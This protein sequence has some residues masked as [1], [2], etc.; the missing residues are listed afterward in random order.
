MGQS[1]KVIDLTVRLNGKTASYDRNVE[2]S[3]KVNERFTKSVRGVSSGLTAVEGPLNGIAGR[4]TAL[5]PIVTGSAGALAAVGAAFAGSSLLTINAMKRLS[6]YEV[7]QLKIQQILKATGYAAGLSSEEL[8]AQADAVALAT[9]ASVEDIQQAQGVLL[10]FKAVQGE[11]FNEAIR[12]SQ[13]MAAVFGGSA[14]DK[15]LQL[16][17][18][19]SSPTDGLNALKRSG[20]DFTEEQKRMIRQMDETGNRAEAQRLILKQLQDQIGGSASAQAQGLAGSVDTLGQRWDEAMRAFANST[21]ANESAKSFLNTL[22][23]GLE[24]VTNALNGPTDREKFAELV[25]ERADLQADL[26]KLSKGERTGFLSYIIG[27]DSEWYNVQRRLGE[28]NKEMEKLQNG[29]KADTIKKSE[30]EELTAVTQKKL[31]EKP[32]FFGFSDQQ[33]KAGLERMEYAISTKEERERMAAENRQNMLDA[34]LFSSQVTEARW[35]ELSTQNWDNYQTKITEIQS[36]EA[37]KRADDEKKQAEALKKSQQEN[38]ASLKNFNSQ[39]L[40][41]LEQSGK[42]RSALYKALFAAQKLAAIPAMITDTEKA[43]IA[44]MAM[45]PGPAGIAVG[46][47]IR[48]I[49]YASVGVVAGQTIAGAFENGGI[50]PGNSYTGDNLMA[51]VNSREMVLNVGQQKQLFD[52][53][54]GKGAGGGGGV[55]VNVIEDASRAGT[56]SRSADDQG[57]E[58]ISVFVANVRSGGDAAMALESIYGMERAGTI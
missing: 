26:E 6:D 39:T 21:G 24:R 34:A 49:G 14:K 25:Q 18:A 56:Q 54:N 8:A 52:I 17:K 38:V 53:A 47:M 19:L 36:R 1:A 50:I 42:K 27:P 10:S 57:Q 44:A 7:Q 46:G 40:Q 31:E 11:T 4:F 58:I 3:K 32:D 15:A 5:T 30:Q 22:A 20:V 41:V 9:L 51:M 2:K 43:A 23:T 45:L 28:V 48:G 13:D 37:Q 12:L 55:V 35:H 33:I 29:F 16:G